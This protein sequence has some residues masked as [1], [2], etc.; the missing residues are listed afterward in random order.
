MLL[1]IF[2]YIFVINSHI[3]LQSFRVDL[4]NS[5]I[6]HLVMGGQE[7]QLMERLR[8]ALPTHAQN[9][10]SHP[11]VRCQPSPQNWVLR[12]SFIPHSVPTL[13]AD[14]IMKKSIS[15]S[16]SIKL[17]KNVA[18]GAHFQFHNHDLFEKV[19]CN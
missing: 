10:E 1:W 9:F 13:I 4:H 5:I 7:L 6:Y 19:Y 15:Y 11:S 16:F 17:K 18:C 3:N 12:L 14:N 8:R 2:T